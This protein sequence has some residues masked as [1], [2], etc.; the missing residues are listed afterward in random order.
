M[1]EQMP[2]AW[3]NDMI[4]LLKAFVGDAID[5]MHHLKRLSKARG[6]SPRE[7]RVRYR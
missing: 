5:L 4:E 3:A 6:R 2:E 1:R 7:A